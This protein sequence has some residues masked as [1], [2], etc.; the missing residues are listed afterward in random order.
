MNWKKEVSTDKYV[1][2]LSLF[3]GIFLGMS[4]F[5]HI[6]ILFFVSF[7]YFIF[8]CL[9]K[10]YA[11][12][13]GIGLS[14]TNEKRRQKLFVGE[15]S[16][17]CFEI[18]NKGLPVLNGK[19][20]ISYESH[21]SCEKEQLGP[22]K[23]MEM[24]IP[25]SL[26]FRE[27][28]TISVPFQAIKRGLSQIKKIELVY[29]NM[30]GLGEIRLVYPSIWK[31]EFLIY[32]KL[33]KV[34]IH[35][36]PN[37]VRDG[38]LSSLFTL[39]EDTLAPIGTRSYVATDPFNRIHWK[40][41][42]RT[43]SLQ[44]KIFDQTNASSM[45]LLLNVN[46]GTGLT[47]YLEELISHLAYLANHCLKEDIPVGIAINIRS[48]DRLPFIYISPARG[49]EHYAKILELLA[50]IQVFH[51]TIPYENVL[52]YLN[53]HMMTQPWMIHSGDM[54]NR[55]KNQFF[56]MKKNGCQIWSLNAHTDETVL[57][58]GMMKYKEG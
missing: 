29:P 36:Q 52:H 57:I 55:Q 46:E 56:K 27:Q 43:Q 51:T 9:H 15:S 41:S 16:E 49:R 28:T 21:I 48:F 54:N 58:S 44:T 33:L 47:V 10:L 4:I 13:S 18:V 12:Y 45:L 7:F 39:N 38:S 50:S 37:I 20:I 32:P 19:W 40:T 3:A 30:F 14:V 5:F 34:N 17:W 6:P 42:A 8:W 35:N 26:K 25:C 1:S 23:W 53:E 24:E 11:H 2:F 31:E 22:N